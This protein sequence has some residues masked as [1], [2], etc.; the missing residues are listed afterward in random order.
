MS[1]LSDFKLNNDGNIFIIKNNFNSSTSNP[2][3]F[4]FT[5]IND[6]KYYMYNDINS[7]LIKMEFLDNEMTSENSA[8]YS[9]TFEKYTSESSS[10]FSYQKVLVGGD[11]L[12]PE[13]SE[14]KSMKGVKKDKLINNNS[15]YIKSID[16]NI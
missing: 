12:L 8:K 1:D 13:E 3:Y 2:T 6:K 4:I 10:G 11:D 7:N 9:F 16:D 5:I 15:Y 14:D